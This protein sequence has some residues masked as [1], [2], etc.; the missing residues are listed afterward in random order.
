MVGKTLVFSCSDL[1]TVVVQGRRSFCREN[2]IEQCVD[3]K[4]EILSFSRTNTEEIFTEQGKKEDGQETWKIRAEQK[5]VANLRVFKHR[6]VGGR[7][8]KKAK[9]RLR[10]VWISFKDFLANAML[11]LCSAKDNTNHRED[12][13]C[14]GRGCR[15]TADCVFN[16]K[17]GRSK[18]S[19]SRFVFKRY[20]G[21][22]LFRLSWALSEEDKRRAEMCNQDVSPLLNSQGNVTSPSSKGTI[23]YSAA[24]KEAVL[25]LEGKRD[26]IS[27]RRGEVLQKLRA[28]N[29]LL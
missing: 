2:P 1:V 12:Q 4:K 10:R 13:I 24:R 18:R 23:I 7:G 5:R 29:R 6:E 17:P 20:P 28:V 26:A 21:F 11:V 27:Q 8:H 15:E 3:T 25:S 16:R 9:V 19:Q 22:I 14:S